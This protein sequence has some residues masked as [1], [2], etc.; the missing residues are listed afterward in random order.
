MKK[1]REFHSNEIENIS[2]ESI[3][4]AALINFV[5]PDAALNRGRCLS[6]NGI[7]RKKDCRDSGYL[8]RNSGIFN[9]K[10]VTF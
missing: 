2:G 1:T 6:G 7:S 10:V 4:C 9:I 5:V 3:G 8:K